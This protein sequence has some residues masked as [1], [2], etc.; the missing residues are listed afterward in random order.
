MQ[1]NSSVVLTADM[2]TSVPAEACLTGPCHLIENWQMR[3]LV[4]ETPNFH[5]QHAADNINLAFK[6]ITEEGSITDRVVAVVTDNG[7]NT[8][9]AVHKAGWRHHPCFGSFM[10][11]FQTVPVPHHFWQPNMN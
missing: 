8:I 6:S 4:L 7:A 3:E 11:H 2:W 5:G 10:D 1:N 9:A